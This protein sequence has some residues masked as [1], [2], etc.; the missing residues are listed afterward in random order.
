MAFERKRVM[1]GRVSKD[2][3]DKSVI[4]E[5]RRRVSDR[6]YGKIVTMR[7]RYAAHDE[8]NECRVGDLVEIRESRP[9]SRTKRWVVT[10]VVERAV[11]V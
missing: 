3:M 4:V 11:E 7:A 8:K 1:T 10:R 6:R 2:K 5:V 9:L